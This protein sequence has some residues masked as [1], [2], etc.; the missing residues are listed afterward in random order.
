MKLTY[1][2]FKTKLHKYK[3]VKQK[4]FLRCRAGNRN[5]NASVFSYRGIMCTP[6]RGRQHVSVFS[7]P[8]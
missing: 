3:E 6:P 1:L 7:V 8:T 4:C 5:E 2:N